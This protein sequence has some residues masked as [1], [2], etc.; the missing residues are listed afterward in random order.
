MGFV[1]FNCGGRRC[2]CPQPSICFSYWRFLSPSPAAEMNV[3]LHPGYRNW[4][5]MLQPPAGR[6]LLYLPCRIASQSHSGTATRL[7]SGGSSAWQQ[8]GSPPSTSSCLVA[9][10]LRVGGDGRALGSWPSGNTR[11]PGDG[12]RRG[13]GRCHPL[14]DR[15]S[16]VSFMLREQ[17][18]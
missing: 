14:Q 12:D 4:Q 10:G 18:E 13:D 11:R 3:W 15:G 9:V 8:R 6:D 17:S 2:H 1:R 7:R 16:V 5:D